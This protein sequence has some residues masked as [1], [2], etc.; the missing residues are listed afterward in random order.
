VRGR[1]RTSDDE[2]SLGS[3]DH[4]H[5]RNQERWAMGDR[6]DLEQD[7][8]ESGIGDVDGLLEQVDYG[9]SQGPRTGIGMLPASEDDQLLYRTFRGGQVSLP[10]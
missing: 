3:F 9:G 1:G 4:G 8:A 2:P 7:P 10:R 5:H 6:R